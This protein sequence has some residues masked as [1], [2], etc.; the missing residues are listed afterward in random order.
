MSAEAALLEQC[1]DYLISPAMPEHVV[2]T[3]MGELVMRYSEPWRHHHT[4]PHLADV[5]G[6]LVDN[7]DKLR[8][9]AT[10]IWSGLLHDGVYVPQAPS[11]VNEALSADLSDAR[12]EP[13]LPST[14]VETANRYIKSTADH[15]PQRGDTDQAYLLDADLKILGAPA[16]EFEAFDANIRKEYSFYAIDVY[17]PGRAAVLESFLDRPR[18]YITDVAYEQFEA[19]AR[20]NLARKIEM[21]RAS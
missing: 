17:N 8:D 18:L 14:Q 7:A 12:L 5:V 4:V 3:Y 6:F 19:Q 13:Y 1:G 2:Q 11:G 21:L 15:S 9:P 10:T 16:E 20:E